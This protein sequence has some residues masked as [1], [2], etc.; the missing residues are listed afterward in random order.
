MCICLDLLWLYE[1]CP[2]FE[3]FWS[4]FSRIRLNTER[5]GVPLLIQSK[6][7]KIRTRKTPNTDTIHTVCHT[8]NFRKQ[9]PPFILRVLQISK[10]YFEI[11]LFRYK[12]LTFSPFN[13]ELYLATAKTFDIMN[14]FNTKLTRTQ[15][16]KGITYSQGKLFPCFKFW[17]KWKQLGSNV[18]QM[19]SA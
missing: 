2:Y 7:E 3:F 15:K 16:S 13:V 11:S 5:Y 8:T 12:H 6:C 18:I 10:F 14:H 4:V 1:K 9:K 17:M 19:K